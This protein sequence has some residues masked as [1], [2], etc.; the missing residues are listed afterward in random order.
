M[1]EPGRGRE[2]E[3]ERGKRKGEG[4]WGLEMCER[5]TPQKAEKEKGDCGN[6][7]AH[8]CVSQREGRE[9]ES[10]EEKEKERERG[11]LKTVHEGQTPL[12]KKKR[13]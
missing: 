3:R 5:Q 7:H 9:G 4:E 12:K 13:M 2:G 11:G 10:E 1:H 6:R 8:P